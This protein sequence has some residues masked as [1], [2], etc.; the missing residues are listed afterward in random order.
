MI[1]YLN[2]LQLF[3]QSLCFT[4]ESASM[5]M[6]DSC[7]FNARI[8]GIYPR[9]G[10]QSLLDNLVDE[11]QNLKKDFDYDL[12]GI[13]VADN[14]SV[15]PPVNIHNLMEDLCKK[16]NFQSLKYTCWKDNITPWVLQ[17]RVEEFSAQ[18]MLQASLLFPCANVQYLTILDRESM[19]RDK[20]AV[21]RDKEREGKEEEMEG[22]QA[23]LNVLKNIERDR[24]CMGRDN[25]SAGR[26]K[27]REGKVQ[28]REY[29]KRKVTRR[30]RKKDEE[31]EDKVEE[32]ECKD[33]ARERKIG[34]YMLVN[35]G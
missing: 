24:E 8:Y 12:E 5:A 35:H 20:E 10:V 27:E 31:R 33:C 25:E 26:D 1:D 18:H 28:E 9:D 15:T 16:L 6:S 30:G 22:W 3:R 17:E 19:G 21:G 13:I 34:A 14:S 23:F 29:S 2:P 4:D 32:W 11:V 7:Y